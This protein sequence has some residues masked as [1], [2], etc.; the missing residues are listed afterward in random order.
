MG[1]LG[2][3][4]LKLHDLEKLGLKVPKF[5]PVFVE[6]LKDFDKDSL[7]QLAEKIHKELACETYAVRSSA[8]IEDSEESSYAGQFMTKLDVEPDALQGAM[9]A[10]LKHAKKYLKGD[11]SKFSLF[12]QEFVEP[13]FAG[14]AFTRDPL[15]RRE[16]LIE[17]YKGR[18]E[19]LVS[20]KVKPKQLRFFWD[21]E[22]DCRDLPN[23]KDGI[24]AL[25]KIEQLYKSPQDVEWCIKDGKW[26]FLQTRP[27]VSLGEEAYEQN[28]LLDDLLPSSGDYYYAR[29]EI[30]EIAPL[31]NKDNFALLKKIYAGGGP[32]HKVYKKYKVYFEPDDFLLLLDGELFVD[33]E[34]E[35]HTLM[36]AYSYFRSKDLKPSLAGFTGLFTSFSN[37]FFLS[38]AK[39]DVYEKL[40]IRL[41]EALVAKDLHDFFVDY[42]LIFEVN[43][44]AGKAFNRLEN[45][46]VRESVAF[47]SVL[48]GGAAI[49]PEVLDFD[50][51]FESS[52]WKGNSLDFSDNTSF[53]RRLD[54]EVPKA[55][56]L[57]LWWESLTS[58]KQKI[59]EPVIKEA[60]IFA[61]LREIGRFLVVRHLN[62]MDVKKTKCVKPRPVLP[63]VLTSF[64][65]LSPSGKTKG[66]S[67]G[68]A[69]GVLL[70]EKKLARAKK[71]SILYVKIMSPDLVKYFEKVEG[72]VS[73]EGGVLSHLAIMARERGV[74]VVSGFN[75]QASAISL[76]DEIQIDGAS[77]EIHIV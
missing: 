7:G 20:G 43:F 70:D 57:L 27:I 4:A 37:M 38:R 9:E 24:L 23:L 34:K 50:V 3:K 29:T 28:L 74:P 56:D 66:V 75:L 6:M 63:G 26:Y 11:L 55:K 53:E 13:D 44:L 14:V 49:F 12:V 76:G 69:K 52:D 65:P 40:F 22:V 61:R 54:T 64:Y 58:V 17:Y 21:R 72:I 59:L 33:M 67:A 8:L 39:L 25:K 1:L 2:D 41:R 19:E 18:G 48:S 16:M 15:G 35:L 36:P 5:F 68:K 51:E 30:S 46:L 62:S 71:S 47:A 60:L 31:P 10:L 73:E 77:G 45:F 42:E 32:V